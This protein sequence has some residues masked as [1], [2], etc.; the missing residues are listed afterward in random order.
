MVDKISKKKPVS[1][2]YNNS[3]T[4]APTRLIDVTPDEAFFVYKDGVKTRYYTLKRAVEILKEQGV[5][6]KGVIRDSE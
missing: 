2:L 3:V 6:V 1:F 5:T 4:Q